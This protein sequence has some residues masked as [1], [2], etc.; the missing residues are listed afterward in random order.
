M[1]WSFQEYLADF[2]QICSSEKYFGPN[3]RMVLWLFPLVSC[4]QHK[5]LGSTG[6]IWVAVD[7]FGPRNWYWLLLKGGICKG[8]CLTSFFNLF[9]PSPSW[10][11]D[12]SVALCVN[13]D[14]SHRLQHFFIT[15]VAGILWSRFLISFFTIFSL[16]EKKTQTN[17]HFNHFTHIQKKGKYWNNHYN[18][19]APENQ[20]HKQSW[21]NQSM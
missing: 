13:L 6:H 8:W 7:P 9:A 20:K 2:L 1:Q 19:F 10:I 17:N 5:G 15:T 12:I 18:F 4:F 14:S 3:L 11:P 21:C 16:G